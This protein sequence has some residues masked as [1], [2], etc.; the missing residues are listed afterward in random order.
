MVYFIDTW[1]I[2]ASSEDLIIF[3]KTA[4]YQDFLCKGT[5]LILNINLGE[6]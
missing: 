2:Q 1:C 3:L 4:I 6:L 5:A